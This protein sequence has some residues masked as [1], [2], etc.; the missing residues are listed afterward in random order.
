M[1]ENLL[2]PLPPLPSPEKSGFDGETRSTAP[3]NG[4]F[5]LSKGLRKEDLDIQITEVKPCIYRADTLPKKH[6]AFQYYFL[7]IT[8]VQGL[9]WIKSIGNPISTN[10]YGYELVSSFESMKDK[11]EN[12]YGKSEIVDYLMCDSIWNEPRDWMQAIQNGE[13]R[14]AARWDNGKT[15]KLPSDLDSIFLYVAAED[16]YTGYI[17]IEYAFA[18]INASEKEI[19]MLEDDAL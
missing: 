15:T 16:T 10:P 3:N 8:P 17:A 1:D 13:R 2:P 19:G 12:I 7:Q 11:L 9:S 6:S 18:N 5:G 14:L 4:P